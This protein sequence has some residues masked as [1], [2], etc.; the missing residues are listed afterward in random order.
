[1]SLFGLSR[2]AVQTGRLWFEISTFWKERP[3]NT[4]LEG[5]TRHACPSPGNH[6]KTGQ[7]RG[8]TAAAMIA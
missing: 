2:W 6:K 8:V 7:M 3:Q 1:M 5:D 4:K